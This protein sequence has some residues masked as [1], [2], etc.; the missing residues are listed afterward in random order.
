MPHNARDGTASSRAKRQD[1]ATGPAPSDKTRP[2]IPRHHIRDWIPMTDQLPDIPW[3]DAEQSPWGVPVLDLRP[4]T[5]SMQSASKDQKAA[6]NLVAISQE[7]GR[8]FR[9]I[10]PEPFI[11][12]DQPLQYLVD[13]DNVADGVL[14]SPSVMEHKW[15]AFVY[16]N[17]ISFVRSWLA[18]VYLVANLEIEDGIAT[19][20]GQHGSIFE[21][22]PSGHRQIFDYL[23]RSHCLH[24]FHPVPISEE[25]ASDPGAVA[26]WCMNQ[27]GKIAITATHHPLSEEM[28]DVVLRSN[29]LLHISIARNDTDEVRKQLDAGVPIDLIAQDGLA[30][31]H[32]ALVTEDESMLRLLL[33][34]GANV[35]MPSTQGATPLMNAVQ[36]EQLDRMQLLLAAGADVNATDNRG[37]T[38]L[39]RA[40]EMG[41]VVVAKLLLDNG[42]NPDAE[43]EGHTPRSLAEARDEK[44]I[45]RL[46]LGP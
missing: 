29:S 38:S 26:L 27:F 8:R 39:H 7:D 3:I 1:K 22:D 42:A 25:E 44:G 11:K 31:M 23:M 12:F 13:G 34:R 24:Q 14:F 43:A 32:W 20:T 46:L 30:T 28:P 37:F 45:L 35:D 36:S 9:N 19:I 4:V 15:A 33:E 6:E 18:E 17:Q 2:P 41:K 10:L 40:C 21:S 5:L 16:D